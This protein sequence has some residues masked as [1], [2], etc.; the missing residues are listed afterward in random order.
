MSQS[1]LFEDTI[2]D[3]FHQVVKAMGGPKKTAHALWPA[4]PIE[5]AARYL[6]HCLDP[7]RAEKLSLSEIQFLLKK[8]RALGCHAAIN[9]FNEDA[10][11]EQAVPH[12]PEQRLADLQSKFIESAAFMQT[13]AAEIKDVT[14]SVSGL[15][16]KPRRGC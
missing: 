14:A 3:A 1:Q 10:D 5:E 4:K 16:V 8:G 9:K 12:E 6:N 2:E 11:Y 7:E 15:R 13:L